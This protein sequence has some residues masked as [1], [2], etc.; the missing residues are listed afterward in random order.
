VKEKL[1]QL[2]KA[3][4]QRHGH[5]AQKSGQYLMSVPLVEEKQ[6]LV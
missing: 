3:E 1:M 6:K 2:S 4:L 5:M